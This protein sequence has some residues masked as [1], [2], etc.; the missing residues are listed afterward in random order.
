MNTKHWRIQGLKNIEHKRIQS[1]QLCRVSETRK[2]KLAQYCRVEAKSR[3]W[4]LSSVKR[5]LWDFWEG[6]RLLQL[7]RGNHL[8]E[9]F[10]LHNTIGLREAFCLQTT[11]GLREQCTLQEM[12]YRGWRCDESILIHCLNQNYSV[13]HWGPSI[14]CIIMLA[15]NLCMIMQ[16]TIPW[17]WPARK[18][19]F[20]Q[21]ECRERTK[22]KTMQHLNSADATLLAAHL[23]R[24]KMRKDVQICAN[25]QICTNVQRC[26]TCKCACR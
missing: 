25:V 13:F 2:I 18:Q 11:I 3:V 24:V 1:I 15:T 14:F 6:R 5:N 9:A 12:L 7:A 10:C 23:M 4:L 21:E 16:A 26:I 8:Q 19:L 20:C 22:M 17:E